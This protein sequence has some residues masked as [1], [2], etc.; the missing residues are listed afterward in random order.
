MFYFIEGGL[1]EEK[2][3]KLIENYLFAE[4][5]PL[6]D[7]LLTLIEGEQPSV[8]KRKEIGD[9]LTKKVIDFV[10]TFIQ[11]NRDLVPKFQIPKNGLFLVLWLINHWKKRSLCSIFNLNPS[12]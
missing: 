7:E 10:E 1:D 5:E 12:L 4:R 9:R 2:T 6:R 3:K 11:W 8:L